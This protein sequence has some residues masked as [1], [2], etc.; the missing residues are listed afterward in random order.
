[1]LFGDYH[2]FAPAQRA[3]VR[4]VRR[5]TRKRPITIGLE[6]FRGS[7]QPALDRFLRGR[8]SERS[9]LRQTS[10]EARW[11][12]GPF[13]AFRPLFDLARERGFGIIGLD[14]PFDV[15]PSL[16]D[17][18]LY[19]AERL[20]DAL[21]EH[22][23]RR[24]FVLIGEMHLAPPHLPSSLVRSA[25][26][27]KAPAPETLRVHFN[28]HTVYF[29]LA[30]KGLTDR[31][32]VFRLPSGAYSLHSASPVVCQQSFL[33]WL[34]ALEEGD[35]AEGTFEPE[36]A[37]RVVRQALRTIGHALGLKVS[38][39]E[40]RVEVTGP[41]DLSFLEREKSGGRLTKS[42]LEKLRK[43]VLSSESC[44][45]PKARLIYLAKSNITHAAEEAAHYLR[46]HL[47][48]EGMDDPKGLVDAFYVRIL[49]EAVGFLGSKLV[50]T[51]RRAPHA[52]E[53]EELRGSSPGA[54][55][56][57]LD[58]EAARLALEHIELERGHGTPVL[59]RIYSAPP[60]V[61]NAVTHMLGYMLGDRL[62]YG[63]VQHKLSTAEARALFIEPFEEEG[64]S[65]LAYFELLGRTRTVRIPRRLPSAER[66]IISKPPLSPET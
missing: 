33:T 12:F 11:P 2:T 5:Q 36:A 50:N 34:D 42:E 53:L 22:P 27:R 54:T 47:S 15:R 14:H 31:H 8:L 48:G 37:R 58:I 35:L 19:A 46:H 56:R 43:H 63:L 51:K 17:R 39:A 6:A 41:E 26:R 3:F 49:N 55:V 44:Y 64:G 21:E 59:A 10:F 29:S 40:R 60:A 28:S 23:E 13:S 20:L 61:F 9:F 25:K 24:V 7:D 57:E 45:I 32:D 66:S 1:V 4:L 65:I 30:E 18:D 62:Y 52:K 38:G 16:A